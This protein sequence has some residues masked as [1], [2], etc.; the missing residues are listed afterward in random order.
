[1]RPLSRQWFLSRLCGVGRRCR[2]GSARVLGGPASSA[3]GGSGFHRP[4]LAKPAVL[5]K[6]HPQRPVQLVFHAPRALAAVHARIFTKL[7]KDEAGSRDLPT[8]S[9]HL[10]FADRSRRPADRAGL[11]LPR[12]TTFRETTLTSRSGPAATATRGQTPETEPP[13]RPRIR[14]KH[15]RHPP[16]GCDRPGVVYP[17]VEGKS[18]E[19][20]CKT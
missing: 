11:G 10:V 1:M 16:I 18:V 8:H 5:S 9:N 15:R 6:A 3:G 2:P 20:Y 17:V 4:A 14:S 19:R 12:R 13:Q 7:Q